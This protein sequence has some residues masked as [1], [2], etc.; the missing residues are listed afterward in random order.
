M[1]LNF[2]SIFQLLLVIVI[3]SY[4]GLGISLLS[5]HINDRIKLIAAPILG[6]AIISLATAYGSY[7]GI[8]SSQIALP[9]VTVLFIFSTITIIVKRGTLIAA[10][11]SFSTDSSFFWIIIAFAFINAAI[12]LLPSIIYNSYNLFG[13]NVTY[14]T[15]SE[16]L[17]NHSYFQA[18]NPHLELWTDHMALYQLGYLRMGAQFFLSFFVALFNLPHTI[19]IYPAMAAFGEFIFIAAIGI[20]VTEGLKRNS[21]ELFFA[22]LLTTFSVALGIQQVMDYFPQIFGLTLTAF[23]FYNVL[24]GF[25]SDKQPLIN[26][27]TVIGFAALIL[28]YQEIVPFYVLGVFIVTLYF[29]LTKKTTFKK[30]SSIIISHALPTVIF[31]ISSY[32]FIKGLYSQ[33]NSLVGGNVPFSFIEY[34]QLL[35]SQNTTYVQQPLMKLLSIAG[36]ISALALVVMTVYK[37][38]K[39]RY[40]WLH[41]FVLVGGGFLV[42]LVVFRFY[43]INPY[44]GTMGNTWAIFK[45]MIWSFWIFTTIIGITIAS[46]FGKNIISKTIVGICLLCLLPSVIISFASIIFHKADNVAFATNHSKTPINEY[47]QIVEFAKKN[48]YTPANL[49]ANVIP[50]NNSLF[51]LGLLENSSKGDLIDPQDRIFTNNQSTEELSPSAADSFYP[52]VSYLLEH[53]SSKPALKKIAGFTIYPQDSSIVYF[54]DGFSQKEADSKEHSTWSWMTSKNAEIRLLIP[55]NKSV[56]FVVDI[57]NIKAGSLNIKDS[58]GKLILQIKFNAENQEKEFTSPV[59]TTGFHRIYLEWIGESHRLSDDSRELTLMF[60]NPKVVPIE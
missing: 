56:K 44:D 13:D 53:S 37:N 46:F 11:K 30:C 34:L 10:L 29:Y 6:F 45:M 35:F 32:I 27:A 15:I 43:S 18:A 41:S 52:W 40:E 51:M 26:T 60:K 12:L 7:I 20:L 33:M 17:R 50:A 9:L 22:L 4:I 36:T 58:S 57:N 5:R 1:Y 3:T 38:I 14:I 55:E 16:Y 49:L 25:H 21:R 59:F 39:E 8:N 23:L 54:K 19:Y 47:E 2:N 28:T 24:K 31:P 48:Q 42:G